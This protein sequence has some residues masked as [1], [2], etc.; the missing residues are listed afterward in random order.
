M[1]EHIKHVREVLR[2]LDENGFN[3]SR[4]LG[5]SEV[6]WR[7]MAGIYDFREGDSARHGQDQTD[8]SD[9]ET[10][11]T[12]IATLGFGCVDFFC[13]FSIVTAEEGS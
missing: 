2:M 13:R 10:S 8:F 9:E 11:K 5:K 3:I 6:K 7:V 1:K 12:Q 4:T